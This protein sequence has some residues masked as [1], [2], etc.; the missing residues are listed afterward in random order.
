MH[1][2]YQFNIAAAVLTVLLLAIYVLSRTYPTKTRLALIWLMISTIVAACADL[3][4]G[5][6]FD[7]GTVGVWLL[8]ALKCS[9]FVA[10]NF[11]V[12]LFFIYVA[13][14]TGAGKRLRIAGFSA[15]VFLAVVIFTSPF[16]ELIFSFNDGNYVRG[17]IYFVLY[18]V[19]FTALVGTMIIFLSRRAKMSDFQFFSIIAYMFAVVGAIAVQFFLEIV[20][21]NRMSGVTTRRL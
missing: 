12:L 20:R 14:L 3:A 16:T 2:I 6:L 19:S 9:F 7:A 15:M 4:F 5:F 1:Y 18:L 10:N 13:D 21:I 17:P 8:Y 11:C